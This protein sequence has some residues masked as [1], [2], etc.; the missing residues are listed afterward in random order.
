M[1]E[2]N[3]DRGEVAIKIGGED[4]ILCATMTNLSKFN[5]A[6][7]ECELED[8]IEKMRS[9]DVD[10]ICSAMQALTVEGS[11][12]K[13]ISNASGLAQLGIMAGAVMLALFPDVLEQEEGNAQA[14][15]AKS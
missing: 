1:R 14:E 9:R 6:I 12:K 3:I 5:K 10:L 2:P 4:L 8:A 7:G 15:P 13:A 11:A